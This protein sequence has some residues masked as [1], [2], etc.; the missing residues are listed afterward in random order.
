MKRTVTGKITFM[1]SN[2][3]GCTCCPGESRH[4]FCR[5]LSVND[6]PFQPQDWVADALRGVPENTEVKITVEVV[7]V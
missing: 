4:I 2:V 1:R 5:F 3:G 6:K 7:E